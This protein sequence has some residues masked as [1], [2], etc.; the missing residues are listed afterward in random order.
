M[1]TW[2]E[3]ERIL[4]RIKEDLF[5]ATSSLDPDCLDD[6]DKIQRLNWTSLNNG[7]FYGL[8]KRA[9]AEVLLER[10][11]AQR[12]GSDKKAQRTDSERSTKVRS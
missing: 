7:D 9:A 1:P 4:F 2:K 10:D 8:V 11:L 3:R 5:G 6:V 12:K